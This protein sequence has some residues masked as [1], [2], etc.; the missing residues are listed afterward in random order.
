MI[1]E[2]N[3]LTGEGKAKDIEIKYSSDFQNDKII[4]R[5]TDTAYA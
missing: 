3:S 5:T 4:S 1:R 2:N